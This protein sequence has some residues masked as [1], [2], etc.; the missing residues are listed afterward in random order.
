MLKE[1]TNFSKHAPNT[2]SKWIIDIFIHHKT[3]I[4]GQFIITS[5]WTRAHDPSP[6]Q[7]KL[8]TNHY[9]KHHQITIMN[10]KHKEKRE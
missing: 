1:V 7:S 4:H 9:K 2:I 10:S 5:H 8:L 6:Q 3:F